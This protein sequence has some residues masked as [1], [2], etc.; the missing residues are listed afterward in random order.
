[1][2]AKRAIV[3][4]AKGARHSHGA[5][6][7]LAAPGPS[8]RSGF[9]LRA[10]TAFTPAKRLKLA[11]DDNEKL[12]R[13]TILAQLVW[14]NSVNAFAGFQKIGHVQHDRQIDDQHGDVK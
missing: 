5:L 13:Y 8:L 14:W 12:T 4:L 6:R 3:C 11:R 2:R 9:R 7:S 1:M 10:L